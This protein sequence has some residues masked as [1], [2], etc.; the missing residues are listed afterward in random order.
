[1][2]SVFNSKVISGLIGRL[3]QLENTTSPEWG[4]MNVSQ[5]IKHC[6]ACEEMYQGKIKIKRAFV[7]K[8]FGKVALKS[9]MNEAAQIKK[10]QPTNPILC[11]EGD[12]EIQ[13]D[14]SKWITLLEAYPFAKDSVFEGFV[15]PF[16][17]PMTK[18][19][20]GKMAYKH[21]DHHLRQFGV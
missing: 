10:N 8:L 15:H 12:D 4:S 14:I 7:G 21:S 2:H 5:M 1:M 17:G 19:Q 18:D 9:L 3:E 20:I 6:I 16:F 11:F 13:T